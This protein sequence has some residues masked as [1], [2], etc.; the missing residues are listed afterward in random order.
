[1]KPCYGPFSQNWDTFISTF[2]PEFLLK[3]WI[4]RNNVNNYENHKIR[5]TK[6]YKYARGHVLWIQT[7]L[8]L[9]ISIQGADS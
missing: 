5:A 2:G 7:P 4:T 1:M 3:E 8:R 6:N 9:N